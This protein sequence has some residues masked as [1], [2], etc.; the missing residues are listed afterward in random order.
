MLLNSAPSDVNGLRAL[1]APF[2]EANT[3]LQNVQSVCG[4]GP[5][6]AV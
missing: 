3:N 2:H 6:A 4:T 1:T 5:S